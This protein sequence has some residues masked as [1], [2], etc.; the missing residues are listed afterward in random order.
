MRAA[1]LS[2]T[3]Q[4]S[5]L[6]L[7]SLFLLSSVG[8]QTLSH[9]GAARS[10]PFVGVTRWSPYGLACAQVFLAGAAACRRRA[11]KIGMGDLVRVGTMDS[12]WEPPGGQLG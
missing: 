5:R 12:S 9:C 3:V 4:P 1:A 10:L 6:V 8:V 2:G 7:P 11:N